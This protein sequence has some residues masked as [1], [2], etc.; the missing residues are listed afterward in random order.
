MFQL[1][2]ASKGS[3]KEHGEPQPS[4]PSALPSAD[5]SRTSVLLWEEHCHECA[6][7]QCYQSCSLYVPRADQK[8]ARFV[9]GICPNPHFSGLFHFGA[10][11]SF[12]R[13]AKLETYLYSNG[14][15]V[16]RVRALHQVD[17]A[18]A[19]V[20]RL[21]ADILQPINPK[22]RLNGALTLFRERILER[23]F[24]G[25]PVTKYD[26]FVLECYSPE[27]EPF[28]LILEHHA[29]TQALRHAFEIQPGWNLHTLPAERFRFDLGGRILLS[30][31]NSAERRLIFTWLDFV[32]FHP[33]RKAGAAEAAKTSQRPAA[34]VKC[35]AWD[36]DNTLWKGVLVED[37]ADGLVPSPE[38]LDLVRQLDERGIIQTVISKN[39]FADA[40]GVVERLGLQDY[41]LFPAIN[42]RP[43]SVNLREV[44]DK[45][46][47]G[48]D[49]FALIDDSAFERAEV[50]NAFPQ[51]RV[52]SIEQMPGLLT[53]D[54]FDVPVTETAKKRRLSYLTEIKRE[55]ER[56]VFSGDEEAFLRSCQL[57]LRLFVPRE[58]RHVQRCLELIQRANQLNMSNRRYTAS[59]FAEL[60]SLPGMLSVAM[61]CGD[62][63][64]EYGIVG[65]ASI[66]ETPQ[67]PRIR[68]MVLSCR[69][70][71]RR[72]EHTFLGWLANREAERGMK[73]LEADLIPTGRN[74]PLIQVFDDLHFVPVLE[75]NGHRLMEL[76]L[77]APIA[78]Q[79]IIALADEVARR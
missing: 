57:R 60:L 59:E 62:R 45:L 34:K 5:V 53:L 33:G 67:N 31:E 18:V 48:V 37:G 38:A 17:R 6:V 24:S 29:D 25:K 46:N 14:T 12:R 2:W 47:I 54:E 3:W 74:T 11:I 64:G 21:L 56:E 41:F 43:K 75:E 52:Y 26:A 58:D 39:N 10:D 50:E 69:V 7:P 15:T 13:W 40:W 63:F 65:F 23:I 1:D 9:Y 44:A 42:W 35:V 4:Q 77:S 73:T 76:P 19:L 36:L 51:V 72:V 30:P 61:D 78:S 8:C 70:A 32:Q 27:T 79:D 20:V 71:Q 49:T 68:D 55:K 16:R 28:R 22:R 66:D